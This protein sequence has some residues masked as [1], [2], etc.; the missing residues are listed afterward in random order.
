MAYGGFQWIPTPAVL[1][2][3]KAKLANLWMKHDKCLKKDSD[4]CAVCLKGEDSVFLQVVCSVYR[5]WVLA[6]AANRNQEVWGFLF[7]CPCVSLLATRVLRDS[8][9][10][11][12]YFVANFGEL[13]GKATLG[14]ST[15]SAILGSRSQVTRPCVLSTG[16]FKT[17][18]S[19]SFLTLFLWQQ[20]PIV[21]LMCFLLIPLSSSPSWNFSW[22]ATS[23]IVCLSLK[24]TQFMRFK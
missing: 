12:I 11:R 7:L 20:L 4:F 10:I 15:A 18:L 16:Y 17:M 13:D 6:R 22:Y 14:L 23:C 1:V 19:P 2:T 8:L 21:K 9:S 24:Y 5:H 3:F